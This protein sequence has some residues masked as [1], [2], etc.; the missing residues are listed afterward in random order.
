MSHLVTNDFMEPTQLDANARRLRFAAPLEEQ[1][2]HEYFDN[3]LA[4]CRIAMAVTL[5]LWMAFGVLDYYVLPESHPQVWRVRFFIVTPVML[6]IFLF[7][8]TSRFRSLMQVSLFLDV[9]T[10]G[11]GL[12][13]I[14]AMA[15][16]DEPGY[17]FYYAGLMLIPLIS[18]SFARMRFWSA[19]LANWTV[20]LVYVVSAIF[21]QN[22]LQAPLG[23]TTFINSVFFI[24][25][26]NVAG[27]SACYSLE[28][29]AR[30]TFVATYLLSLERDEQKR[31]REQTESM[32]EILSQ[33]IGVIVHDL[34]T[35]LTSVQLGADTLELSIEKGRNDR[36]TLH[37]ITGF[38]KSGSQM[39]NFLRLSLME[40]LRVLEGQPVPITRE[41]TSLRANIQEGIRYQKPRFS[42]GRQIMLGNAEDSH[43]EDSDG[44]DSDGDVE[45]ELDKMR[46][47]TVWMNLIG[48]A[49]KYSDGEVNVYWRQNAGQILITV[50]DEGMKGVGITRFQASQLFVAFGRLESHKEIEG[51]SFGLLSAQKIVEA[52]GGKL[53]I[54]GHEN[55]TVDSPLFSGTDE[56]TMLNGGFRTAFVVSLPL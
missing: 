14:S 21:S 33:A 13:L 46:M 10:G 50:A 51:T 1:F 35:P 11:F 49:L 24:L 28:I 30:R 12:I 41:L 27:M 29:G 43:G 36:E 15:Q 2:R 4:I 16:P 32:L 48:N 47:I 25:A 53:W 23:K 22:I 52:H 3:S 40:Q 44:E 5:V 38:I 45:L 20:V 39:L 9:L 8:F 54:E 34:G 7:S 37:R 19:T 55:G 31:K 56:S 42:S 18:Y 17:S 6:C 26:A